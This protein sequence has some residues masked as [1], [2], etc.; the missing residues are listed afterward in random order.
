MFFSPL[1]LELIRKYNQPGP[2]YTSYPTALHFQEDFTRMDYLE[3]LAEVNQQKSSPISLYFHLPY[4]DTLC[5]YCGCNMLI[6]RDRQRIQRYVHYL[7]KE[8]TLLKKYLNPDR[9]ALQLHWGGGTPTHLSPEEIR[10]L[11]QHITQHFSFVPDAECSCEIDPRELSLEHLSALR[12][13]G[14]NRLSMGVQDF[15]EKVQKAVN[16][17]QPES[18]TRQVVE[19][20]R[21]LGFQSLNLDL[22][23]GL[24]FQSLES[25]QKTIE[26]VID[27]APDRIALFN[28]AHV[29]WMKKHMN[30]IHS[31]DLPHP[32]EKL[33]ILKMSIE[34]LSQ[35]G[36]L[37]IGMD[38][39]A[40]PNN[41]LSLALQSKKLGRNFQG[42]TTHADLELYGLGMTSISQLPQIYAQNEKT[43]KE[44]FEALDQNLLPVTKG[45][46]LN[47]DDQLRRFVIMRLMCDFE[48]DFARI[49]QQFSIDF[50]SYFASSLVALQKMAEDQLLSLDAKKLVVHPL[51][52]L[53][54][55]NIAMHFDRYLETQESQVNRYSK[56]V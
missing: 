2:R 35:A 56:T 30:L 50:T 52:R 42:Y 5:Y 51:G 36:Y 19:W 21:T 49:E 37:F 8:I 11:M 38:H 1:D 26:T 18:I 3:A 24:P 6:S 40:K 17:I 41:E 9:F 46:R 34:R 12:E 44:Y 53:L 4:C 15:N 48:L 32:E 55:R 54:I 29:P 23:Y 39:F 45:Y 14:F 22:I 33:N 7:Q 27:I 16:R 25:F 31:E 20:S 13:T 28:Y 43:E 10:Q 47:E